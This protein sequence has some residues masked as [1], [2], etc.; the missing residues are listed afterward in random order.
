MTERASGAQRRQAPEQQRLDLHDAVALT[1]YR[2]HLEMVQERLEGLA[3]RAVERGAIEQRRRLGDAQ[4]FLRGA[5]TCLGRVLDLAIEHSETPEGSGRRKL[6]RSGGGMG[7][8]H[9]R[10]VAP[11]RNSRQALRWAIL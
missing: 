9:V 6:N 7:P 4:R 3:S 5:S 10:Y 11:N 2:I 1:A 8:I